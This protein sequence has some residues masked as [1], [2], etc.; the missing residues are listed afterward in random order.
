MSLQF[1]DKR[2]IGAYI[3]DAWQNH[4]STEMDPADGQWFTNGP[5]NNGGLYGKLT[6]KLASELVFDESKKNFTPHQIAANSGIADNRNGLTPEQTLTLTY[7]YQDSSSSSHSTTNALKVGVG[8]DV[9]FTGSLVLAGT[10]VTAKFST[11]YS[12]SWTNA[13][14][15]TKTETKTFTQTVPVKNIPNGK[16]YQVVLLCNNDELKIPYTANIYLSGQSSACFASP[17]N[18]QKIW[19]V[20]AGTLCSWINQYGSAGEE[21]YKYGRDPQDPLQGMISLQ[22]TITANQTAN[23]TA[24]TLDITDSFK[25]TDADSIK[26]VVVGSNISL[27]SAN[28]VSEEALGR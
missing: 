21:S 20:D 22:G 13:T 18:G 10:E 11:E 23:F 19:T 27:S 5:D 9:K 24:R 16:I 17:V 12:Y 3:I 2:L 25:G 1:L 7:A 14:T 8:V 28:M 26:R 4:L 15:I 6:D